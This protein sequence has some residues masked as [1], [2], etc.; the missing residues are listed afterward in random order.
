[1]VGVVVISPVYNEF[2]V[3]LCAATAHM[4]HGRLYKQV[5]QSIADDILRGGRSV[6]I[7]SS[8]ARAHLF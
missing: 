7:N 1:M 6:T 3:E 2:G 4:K 8:V 5:K